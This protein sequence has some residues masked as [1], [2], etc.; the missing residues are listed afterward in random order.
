M[1]VQ[2]YR[3]LLTCHFTRNMACLH[4][5][6]PVTLHDQGAHM[7]LQHRQVLA[8]LMRGSA[9]ALAATP[10]PF[11]QPTSTHLAT[12]SAQAAA[13][14]APAATSATCAAHCAR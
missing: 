2:H 8:Q 1:H 10:R 12:T 3:A 14:A 6:L 13:N 9:K 11:C 7:A 5:G 4:L